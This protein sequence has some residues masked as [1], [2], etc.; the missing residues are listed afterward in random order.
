MLLLK[1]CP[2]CRGDLVFEQD[3]HTGYLECVQCGHIL[4]AGEERRLGVRTTRKGLLR[5]LPQVGRGAPTTAER[6]A[7]R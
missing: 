1:A 4:S 3:A 2:H 7:A 6:A 5:A